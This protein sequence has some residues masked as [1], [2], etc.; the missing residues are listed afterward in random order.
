MADGVRYRRM[1]TRAIPPADRF[2]Y[3]R[4]LVA[5]LTLE[6]VERTPSGWERKV[7]AVAC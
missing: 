3:W 5:P 6:P 1:D 2:E 7:Q 4:A